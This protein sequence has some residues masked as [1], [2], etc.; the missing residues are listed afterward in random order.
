MSLKPMQLLACFSIPQ[1]DR[2]TKTGGSNSAAIVGKGDPMHSCGLC[3]HLP[4]LLSRPHVP[5]LDHFFFPTGNRSFSISRNGY[6]IHPI[7]VSLE[8]LGILT[9][10]DI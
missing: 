8:S 3:F 4:N 1:G 10:L 2:V 7:F 5:E 6:R 9:R